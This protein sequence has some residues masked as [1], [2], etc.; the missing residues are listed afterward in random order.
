M[1]NYLGV[2]VSEIRTF[3]STREEAMQAE[4]VIIPVL[5]LCSYFRVV[6][7][8]RNESIIFYFDLLVWAASTVPV[9]C[10]HAM[11]VWYCVVNNMW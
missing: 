1:L 10:A 11:L 7:K 5:R 8:E 9:R 3:V 6:P 2:Q 4:T